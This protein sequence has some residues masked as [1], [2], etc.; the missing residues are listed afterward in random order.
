MTHIAGLPTCPCG[1]SAF[2]AHVQLP[3]TLHF[4]LDEETLEVFDP[5][6]DATVFVSVEC[7]DCGI[8]DGMA[9]ASSAQLLALRGAR[10]AMTLSLQSARVMTPL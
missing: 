4:D 7:L 5:D 2:R 9:G 8:E 3:V 6:A 1:S 10:R